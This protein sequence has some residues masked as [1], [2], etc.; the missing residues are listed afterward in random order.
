MFSGSTFARARLVATKSWTLD[1][2]AG[3]LATGTSNPLVGPAQADKASSAAT[4]AAFTTRVHTINATSGQPYSRRLSADPRQLL[5][6]R[7]AAKTA[8]LC[9]PGINPGPPPPGLE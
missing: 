3:M 2:S 8:G 4:A 6:P 9:F 7:S 5:R 1:V